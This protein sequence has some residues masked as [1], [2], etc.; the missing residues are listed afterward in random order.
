MNSQEM[1]FRRR[2][3]MK[4]FCIAL[5]GGSGAVNDEIFERRNLV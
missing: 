2:S 3:I 5:M 1:K 4:R